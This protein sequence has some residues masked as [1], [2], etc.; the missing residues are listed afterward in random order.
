MPSAE[1]ISTPM[2][3]EEAGRAWGAR[4]TDWAYFFEPYARP[5]NEVIFDQLG[6]GEGARLL[7]IA[8][9]SGFAAQLAARRGG[10]VTGIDASEALIQ[11]ARARTPGGDF[12]V[13]DMFALPFPDACFDMATSFNGIWKGCEAALRE[14]ARVLVPGG[15]LG[16]TFWGRLEHVGLMPYFLKAIELSP[17]SHGQATI[18]QGDTGRPGVIEEMLVSAGFV[19]RERGTVTVINEWPDASARGPGTSRGRPLGPRHPGRRA[20]PVL[21]SAAGGDRALAH[22]RYRD[23]DCIRARLDHRR[24]P[25]Q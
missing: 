20:R 25:H 22:S 18:R 11:I 7:D 21:P 4:S 15:R 9:G 23:P 19:P 24:T 8:C 12:R 13:A 10:V 5:A 6:I 1:A 17:P 16:L 2:D 14:A 3:W